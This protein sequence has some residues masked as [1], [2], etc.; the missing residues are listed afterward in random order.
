MEFKKLTDEEA[1]AWRM[2]DDCLDDEAADRLL[3]ELCGDEGAYDLI[4]SVCGCAADKLFD[5][6][7]KRLSG[8]STNLKR[9]TEYPEFRRLLMRAYEHAVACGDAASC[10]NL[11]NMYHETDNSGTSDDYATAVQL[12]ELGASRGDDQSS[13]NLGY[14]YYYGRGREVDYVRAYECW[15]RAALLADN[16][17]AYWK[18]GDLYAGG[19]GVEKS[20]AVAWKMYCIAHQF[21]KDSPLR[22]RAAHHMADYLLKGIDGVVDADPDSALALYNEAEL[23]YYVLMDNGLMYYRRQLEQAI[24]GQAKAREAAAER[25]RRIQAGE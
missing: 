4:T 13:V 25:H 6:M 9:Y 11:G 7:H 21:C 1:E 22:A 15:A 14:I 10:C 24:E 8:A 19:K 17:E 20:D 5:A 2:L 12:Y 23:G 18:L 3:A 16:P